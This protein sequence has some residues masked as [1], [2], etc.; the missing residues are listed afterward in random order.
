MILRNERELR[1]PAAANFLTSACHQYRVFQIP[2]RQLLAVGDGRGI[3][4]RLTQ[5]HGARSL[6]DTI[7]VFH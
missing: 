7:A 4:N 3:T 5:R 6:R 2:K 1:L